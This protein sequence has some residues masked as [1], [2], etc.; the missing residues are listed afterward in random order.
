MIKVIFYFT[1]FRSLKW[2]YLKHKR[3]NKIYFSWLWFYIVIEKI[4][5]TRVQ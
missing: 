5:P 2:C 1:P 3:Y 4:A